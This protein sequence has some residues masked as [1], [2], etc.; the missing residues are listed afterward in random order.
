M[1]PGQHTP[2]G[3][4][5]DVDNLTIS[6]AELAKRRQ[7]DDSGPLPGPGQVRAMLCSAGHPNP[8]HQTICRTCAGAIPAGVPVIVERPPLAVLAFSS[9]ERVVVDRSVIIGRNPKVT[10]ASGGELPRIA[11]FDDESTLGLSRSHAQIVVEGWQMFVEDL[12]SRNGTE[13]T[14]PGRARQRLRGG[15]AVMLE[16]GAVIHL[17]EDLTCTVEASV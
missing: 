15:E 16:V 8:P 10:E 5:D 2:A 13:L 9:A 12:H 1:E 14:L 17:D 4:T 3:G 6:R 11:R 7:L